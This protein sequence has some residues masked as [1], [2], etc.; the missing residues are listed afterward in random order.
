MLGLVAGGLEYLGTA[1]FQPL[2]LLTKGQGH[3]TV[4]MLPEIISKISVTH[5]ELSI[6]T[7]AFDTFIT[8]FTA[9][10]EHICKHH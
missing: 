7:G 5:V 9:K 2:K 3:V 6:L 4:P 10:V 1:N 8:G